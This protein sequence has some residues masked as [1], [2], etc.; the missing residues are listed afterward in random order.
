MEL[1]NS[2]IATGIKLPVQ[3]PRN[4]DAAQS[5]LPQVV[6]VSSEKAS[7]VPRSEASL[8]VNPS[9]LVRKAEALQSTRLQRD[10]TLE[11]APLKGQQAITAYQQTID[12]ARQYDEGE[13]VGIDLYV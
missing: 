11:D 10:N 1:S 7:N 12:A 6:P 3:A 9:D 8:S 5:R 13:L 2:L 4:Q